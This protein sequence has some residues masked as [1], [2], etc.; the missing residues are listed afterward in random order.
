MSSLCHHPSTIAHTHRLNPYNHFPP[1]DHHV[2]AIVD[3]LPIFV[4]EPSY[5]PAAKLLYQVCIL[6][7]PK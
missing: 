3:T 7:S 5:F 2:T 6:I 4:S 1:W